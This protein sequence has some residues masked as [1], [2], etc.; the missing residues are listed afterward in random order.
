MMSNGT[1]NFTVY[2]DCDFIQSHL[3]IMKQSWQTNVSVM[4]LVICATRLFIELLELFQVK[5]LWGLRDGFSL[6]NGKFIFNF[7]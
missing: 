5:V 4:I 3:N 1:L 2:G 6:L 7:F